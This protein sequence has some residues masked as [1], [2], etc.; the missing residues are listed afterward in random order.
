MGKC[1]H[2]FVDGWLIEPIV[3][4]KK[5]KLNIETIIENDKNKTMDK[6]KVCAKPGGSCDECPFDGIGLKKN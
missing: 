6:C 4:C 5:C 2:S 3:F 1:E